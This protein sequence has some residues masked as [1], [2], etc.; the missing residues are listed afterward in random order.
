MKCKQCNF[1]NRPGATEC[2]SC[3]VVFRDLSR[4]APAREAD[5][6]CWLDTGVSCQHRGVARIDGRWL[7][8]EHWDCK[9]KIAP[10]G[11]GNYATEPV[12]SQVMKA[13]DGWYEGW[14]SRRD[15]KPMPSPMREPGDDF[16]DLVPDV[17]A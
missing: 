6:C 7:C 14:K 10:R 13:W 8:R 5:L 11:T 9:D 16:E 17:Q 1:N 15:K 3:G 4:A 12:R 2:D